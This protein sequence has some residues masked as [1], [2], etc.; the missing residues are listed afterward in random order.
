ME[1]LGDAGDKVRLELAP[2]PAD[3]LG[4]GRAALGDEQV[5]RAA[6]LVRDGARGRA[7]GRGRVRVTAGAR[8][9]V[10]V[11]ARAR[12]R[13]GARGVRQRTMPQCTR[14]SPRSLSRIV[15]SFS[16]A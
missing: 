8:V 12:A 13:A 5:V 4:P 7:R 1:Q 16:L 11:G 6:A 2:R 15:L 14:G 9:R 10:G 3:A